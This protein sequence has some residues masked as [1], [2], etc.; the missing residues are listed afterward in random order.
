MAMK[1]GEDHQPTVGRPLRRV[2]L[3][4][5]WPAG[6]IALAGL[7]LAGAV[8]IAAIQGVDVEAT[9]PR[10]WLLHAVVIFSVVLAILSLGAVAEP[11]RMTFRK[12]LSLAPVTARILLALALIYACVTFVDFSPLTAA[13]APIVKG[14][15]YFFD[16]HGALSEVTEAQFGVQRSMVLRLYSAFWIYLFLFC[17]VYLLA[18][19]RTDRG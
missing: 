6:V 19:R 7:L 3:W 8:H 16:N 13:G 4:C 5:R 1:P 10:V 14:G 12:F 15:R 2:I 9:W 11:K 17:A 18:A